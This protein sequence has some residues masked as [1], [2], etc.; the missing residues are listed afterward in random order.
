MP[1][2]V[3]RIFKAVANTMA[4]RP[5]GRS[6]SAEMDLCQSNQAI[7][8]RLGFANQALQLG[9]LPTVHS[10]DLRLTFEHQP[11]QGFPASF[12]MQ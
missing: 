5:K 12:A 11:L 1:V 8:C 10:S 7:N 6:K 3:R 9:R 4:R 2:S